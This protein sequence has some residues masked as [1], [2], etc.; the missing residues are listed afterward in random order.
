[1]F[2]LH[3][4]QLCKQMIGWDCCWGRLIFCKYCSV[5]S[6]DNVISACNACNVRKAIAEKAPRLLA[7]LVQLC[8]D[9]QWE[10]QNHKELAPEKPGDWK[11]TRVSS[12]STSRWYCVFTLALEGFW[13]ERKEVHEV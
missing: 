12:V 2:Q 6:S 9:V 4:L 3:V 8:V 11:T 5:S 1:M 13:V 7:S 10:I